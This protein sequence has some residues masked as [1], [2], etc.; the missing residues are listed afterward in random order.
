MAIKMTNFC[1]A[2][3]ILSGKAMIAATPKNKN[4]MYLFTRWPM[5]NPEKKTQKNQKCR[6]R[7]HVHCSL[8]LVAAIENTRHCALFPCG[9]APTGR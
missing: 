9:T 1:P 3:A 4:A 8:C 7:I 2:L 6:D 5:A